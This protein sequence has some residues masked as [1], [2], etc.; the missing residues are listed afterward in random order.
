MAGRECDLQGLGRSSRSSR[1]LDGR[2]PLQGGRPEL[3]TVLA[4]SFGGVALVA[5]L[6]SVVVGGP[7]GVRPETLAWGLLATLGAAALGWLV[8]A[9]ISDPLRE[10]R[11]AAERLAR[12]SEAAVPQA[13]GV[14]EVASMADAL[15]AL[16]AAVQARE[17]ALTSGAARLRLAT[18]GT[19]VGT[20]ELDLTTGASIRSPRHDAIFGYG[21]PRAEWRYEDF[22]SH[23]PPD[24]HA[25]VT[26]SFE[27]AFASGGSWR[28]ECRIRRA[29]DGEMRWIAARGT[30]LRDP[31][32]GE[33]TRYAGVVE[34][35]TERK[36]S[37]AA[38]LLLMREL[39]HRVKNQFAV[40]DGLIQ[41]TARG[42]ADVGSMVGA[43]RGRV[44][45]L[46]AAHDLVR[47]AAGS[48]VGRGLGPTTVGALL[49]AVLGPFGADRIGMAGEEVAIG[50]AA[51]AALALAFHELATN[52]ARHGALTRPDGAV[53]I[54]W[55]RRKG[56]HVELRWR[57]SGGPAPEAEPQR[58]GFGS[59][60][61]RQSVEHQLGGVMRT[62]WAAEGLCATFD[63]PEARLA[64]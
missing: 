63:L 56:G 30:P 4:L 38:Q 39:D 43:L 59:T 46:A 55:A 36:A 33:V 37:E 50:P 40:F 8:T 15:A 64:R 51:A 1:T 11:G 5:V 27:E 52:A 16:A 60:L 48:G 20:W 29:D 9:L 26:R 31:L 18:E 13:R 10:L 34:D 6:G 47:D 45:A 21:E 23:V 42:A 58:R 14:S 25:L 7:A 22:I 2:T 35:I 54:G 19:G 53:T 41:F 62:E 49:R 44:Q 28:F 61:I 17:A 3:R 57:E 24:D 12:D 32:S